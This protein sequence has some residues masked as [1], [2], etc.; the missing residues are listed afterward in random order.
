[1]GESGGLFDFDVF[2]SQ[3]ET[4]NTAAA[5]DVKVAVSD[6]RFCFFFMCIWRNRRIKRNLCWI[7]LFQGCAWLNPLTRKTRYGV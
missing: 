7:N 5:M 4:I 6:E 2:W 3:P 1:M